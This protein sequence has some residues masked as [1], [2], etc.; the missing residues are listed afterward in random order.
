MVAAD[1]PTVIAKSLL[2]PVV[3]EN[4]Q[5]D[6]RLSDSASADESDWGE[7][8]GETDD[9][10]DQLAASEE[11]PWGWRRGFSKYIRF[12]CEMASPL[13]VQIADPGSSLGDS[14]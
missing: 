14:P 9:L 4:G 3:V 11:R 12:E 13:A 1:E 5:G 8:L 2:D 10:V 6:G 7:V